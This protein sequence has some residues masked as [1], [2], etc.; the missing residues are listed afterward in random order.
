MAEVVLE[1]IALGLKGVDIL[2]LDLPTRS[3]GLHQFFDIFLAHQVT[4][5]EGG[6]EGDFSILATDAQLGPVDVE[7]VIRVSKP[8]SVCPAVAP[9]LVLAPRPT[10]ALQ[11]GYLAEF[12]QRGDLF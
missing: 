2:V 12:L 8:Y 5:D 3:G 1:V 11:R 9:D 7:A 10:L 4:A 6:V